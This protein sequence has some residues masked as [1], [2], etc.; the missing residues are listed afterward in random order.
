MDA[1]SSITRID[2]FANNLLDWKDE[3]F[4]VQP[5]I[6]SPELDLRKQPISD[7]RVKQSRENK[8]ERGEIYTQSK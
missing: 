5:I 3:L 7:K 4:D 8:N 2:P 6:P 1:S